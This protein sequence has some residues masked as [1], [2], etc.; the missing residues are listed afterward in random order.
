MKIQYVVVKNKFADATIKTT[1]GIM[2]R[3]KK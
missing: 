3:R 2:R 1:E